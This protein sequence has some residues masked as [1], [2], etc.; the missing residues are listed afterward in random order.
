MLKLNKEDISD[1]ILFKVGWAPSKKTFGVVSVW[2]SNKLPGLFIAGIPAM[3]M[4]HPACMESQSQT[5]VL[6]RL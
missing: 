4:K 5:L 6:H 2:W 3:I 1:K